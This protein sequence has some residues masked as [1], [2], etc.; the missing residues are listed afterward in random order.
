MKSWAF[1]DVDAG[2]GSQDYILYK[3]DKKDRT[4]Y[5]SGI[6]LN[7]HIKNPDDVEAT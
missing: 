4:E 5:S 6:R 2:V 7:W 3:K 1:K